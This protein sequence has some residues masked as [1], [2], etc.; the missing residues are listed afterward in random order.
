MKRKIYFLT[1]VGLLVLFAGCKKQVSDAD[2]IRSGINQH[3]ASLKTLNLDAMDMNV[4][5]VSIQGDQAQAQVE[6]KPK[7][8]APQ[9]TGMQVAYVLQKQNGAWVVQNSQ[10][11]AGAM[12]H[13]GPGENPQA[14]A[15][16]QSPD[17]MPN[18]RD[19]VPGG[20]ASAPGNSN[21]PPPGHPPVNSQG[22]S[23]SQ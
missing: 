22:S 14:G 11:T 21:A 16:S 3:L 12:Q 4:T 6:F 8:G 23:Y 13:P 9:G 2:A 1:F 19:L 7:G 10:A 17:S 15:P 20:S 18:F 5:S